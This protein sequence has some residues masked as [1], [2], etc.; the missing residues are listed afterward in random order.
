MART[1]AS[2][3]SESKE[4]ENARLLAHQPRCRT[5]S[6]ISCRTW[7]Q[8]ANVGGGPELVRETDAPVQC[9]PAHELREE[10]VALALAAFP[11]ARVRLAP[12]LR[13]AVDELAD[14]LRRERIERVELVARPGG[15]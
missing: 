8:P 12:V 2:R 4:P 14:E 9:E 1:A 7:L 5:A 6:A 10:V 15:T 3:W 13:S 11:D